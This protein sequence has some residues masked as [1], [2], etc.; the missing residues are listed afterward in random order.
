MNYKEIEKKVDNLHMESNTLY[1]K[2]FR[3]MEEPQ[4]GIFDKPQGEL[5]EAQFEKFNKQNNKFKVILLTLRNDLAFKTKYHNTGLNES[6]KYKIYVIKQ[7]LTN[8]D[9]LL[10]SVYSKYHLSAL[11]QLTNLTAIFLPL[12]L[13]VGWFG[14]NFN[15]MSAIRG[16]FSIAHGQKYVLLLSILS[17]II[18]LI[19]LKFLYNT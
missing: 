7:N 12:T 15:S 8:I 4:N 18:M 3:I 6:I 2:I 19:I 14:M 10:A 9:T 17:I 16:I 13:I 11:K 5:T 1:A